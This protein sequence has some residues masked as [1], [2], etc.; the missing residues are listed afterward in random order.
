MSVSFQYYSEIERISKNPKA[1]ILSAINA[2]AK[3]KPRILVCTPSNTAVDNVIMKIIEER[4]V[5]GNGGRYNPSI[6]RIGLGHSPSVANVSLK[7][8]MDQ[9]LSETMNPEKLD[10]LIESTR[11]ELKRLQKEIENL[12]R[13]VRVSEWDPYF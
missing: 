8:K 5:D 7:K 13:R 2:A 3:V 6:V 9:I 11:L 4:F 10:D 1:G 12:Q